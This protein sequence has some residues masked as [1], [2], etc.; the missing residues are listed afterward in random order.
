MFNENNDRQW[1]HVD[2]ID[3]ISSSSYLLHYAIV[4]ARCGPF[5][6]ISPR[7][8]STSTRKKSWTCSIKYN[9]TNNTNIGQQSNVRSSSFFKNYLKIS[10]MIF[11]VC[12][13][14]IY[15]LAIEAY[16]RMISKMW[17]H[18]SKSSLFD[19]S[20]NSSIS[21]VFDID[22]FITPVSIVCVYQ[23]AVE[24]YLDKIFYDYTTASSTGWNTYSEMRN[25]ASQKYG[26]NLHEPHLPSKTLEQVTC[27]IKSNF[28][29]DKCS[30]LL[31]FLLS[32][33]WCTWYIEK[34]ECIRISTLL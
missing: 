24:S 33:L 17:H 29:W 14:H 34:F 8:L 27:D 6:M 22:R 26:L 15:K 19:V 11:V 2:L 4:L 25:I 7:K 16:S 30:L 10:K 28:Y 12:V 23:G 18:F 20:M 31:L 21:K 32:G 1:T 5:V 3:T 13:T 9:D